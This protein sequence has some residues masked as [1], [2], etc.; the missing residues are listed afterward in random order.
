MSLRIRLILWIGAVLT[1]SLVLGS[2]LVYWH[3]VRK[4]DTEMRAA[5]HVGERTIR[6]AVNDVEEAA[7]PLRHL[8]LLVANLNGD[9]HL[10]ATLIAHDGSALARSIPL[11]PAEP[12]PDWFY[13]TLAYHSEIVRVLLPPPFDRYGSILLEPDSRNEISEVWSDLILTLAILATFCLLIAALVYWTTGRALQPL[14]QM[15]AAFGSIGGGDYELHVSERGPRELVQLSRGFNAM[16]ERLRD[17]ERRK[18]RLEEQILAVQEEERAELA[19]DLHD[20]IGPLLFAAGVDLLAMQ[21]H[22]VM[23]AQHEL[24]SRVDATLDAIA[25]MQMH[26][27]TILRRLRPPTIADLGLSISLE[28]LVT[29]WQLRYPSVTFKVS[30]PEGS[31]GTHLDESIYRIVQE[32]V[33]NALRH[34]HPKR[35]EASIALEGDDTIVVKVSDDGVGLQPKRHAAGLGLTGMQER[36]SALGGVLQVTN[37]LEGSGVAVLAR[38]PRLD[39]EGSHREASEEEA[40][41]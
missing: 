33:S 31:F 13:Q 15:V 12:A 39:N 1:T 6:N 35:V 10:R 9:R 23:L 29:F 36:V 7:A 21:Q 19:R 4:V 27:R 26:V 30:V 3:A 34:G 22:P 16:V 5:L 41:E 40:V 25:H 18:Q 24:H 38:L 37:R 20:E 11:T 17:I 2:V 14:S 32:S 28:N 8:Q